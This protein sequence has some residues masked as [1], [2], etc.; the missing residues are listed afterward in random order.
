[1]HQVKES[2][3]IRMETSTKAT[4]AQT[5]AMAMANTR[6]RI[7]PNTKVSGR[8]ICNQVT[9]PRFGPKDRNTT[10]STKKERSKDLERTRGPTDH[11]T[12]AIGMT[13][14]SMA[15]VN[16]S[17]RMAVNTSAPGKTTICT[18]SA[19]TFT[20]MVSRMKVS[21]L[22][23]RKLAT[24]STIGQM[25]ENMRAGGTKESNTAW[26]SSKIQRRRR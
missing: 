11:F 7:E 1:M 5:N 24:V 10:E 2:S 12:L 9:E 3:T 6:I 26:E 18:E 23:I 21:T 4:G 14:K 19:S 20:Q 13:I 22:M 15:W 8:M 16:I 25:E 17:G